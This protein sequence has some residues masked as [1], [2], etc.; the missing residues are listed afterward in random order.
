[1]P[2][3]ERVP[4]VARQLEHQADVIESM[5]DRVLATHASADLSRVG[6]MDQA[7]S[8]LLVAARRPGFVKAIVMQDAPLFSAG[9]TARA[10]GAAPSWEPR[11][12]TA[13]LLVTVSAQPLNPPADANH[14]GALVNS[15]RYRLA[16]SAPETGHA[17]LASTAYV[18]RRALGLGG[19]QAALVAAF[20]A[21]ARA[22]LLFLDAWLR[23]SRAQRA[24]LDDRFQAV[25]APGTATLEVQ[26]GGAPGG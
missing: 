19:A 7:I 16:L 15:R 12:V 13:P 22:Q 20:E 9:L 18:V 10:F 1:M 25:I 26:A 4:L 24:L 14:L 2:E 11:A 23:G 21:N 5:V 6:I 17:D 8:T 3:A